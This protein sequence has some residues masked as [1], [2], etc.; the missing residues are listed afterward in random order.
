MRREG[1]TLNDLIAALAEPAEGIELRF[2]IRETDFRAYGEEVIRELEQYAHKQGWEV[3]DDSR[4]G[5]RI[6]F[7]PAD[8]DGWLLLRLSVH[9][10]VMPLN[11]ESDRRGG[12]PVRSRSGWPP[13][14]PARE[15]W[16]PPP[17]SSIWK[18]KF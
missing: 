5:V 10:P 14:S 13:S 18:N 8:G 2:S 9:D 1:R 15:G 16:M 11:I 3:A 7:G 17:W 6:S 4:E 12:C